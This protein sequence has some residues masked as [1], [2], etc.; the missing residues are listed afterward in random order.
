LD[1]KSSRQRKVYW[2]SGENENTL[3]LLDVRESQKV[4]QTTNSSRIADGL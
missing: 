1:E 4:F 3:F 2:Q